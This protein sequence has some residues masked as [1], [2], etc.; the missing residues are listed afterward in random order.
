MAKTAALTILPRASRTQ[1]AFK[2]I[3]L[4]NACIR[5]NSPDE[6]LARTIDGR[7]HFVLPATKIR[8]M[9]REFV[10]QVQRTI[11]IGGTCRAQNYCSSCP[12]CWI[13]GTFGNVGDN[14][15]T[16]SFGSRLE[17][18]EAIAL[19]P[20][21]EVIERTRN[22]VE[23]VFQQTGSAGLTSMNLVPA[24]TEFYGELTI[25]GGLSDVETIVIGA[26]RGVNRVGAATTIL[27]RCSVEILAVRRGFTEIPAW[28]PQNV[29]R[30]GKVPVNNGGDAFPGL[31][32]PTYET[33]LVE[34]IKR[35]DA[36][37]VQVA[38]SEVLSISADFLKHG[39]KLLELLAAAET[40]DKSFKGANFKS[41][42]I[43][44]TST[45]K[46]EAQ[47][48]LREVVTDVLGEDK[49]KVPTVA[50]VV[51]V[52]TVLRE[53]LVDAKVTEQGA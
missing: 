8:H 27:G 20:D 15:K 40:G 5:S 47:N 37:V 48:R 52:A 33:S 3:L 1:I 43:S 31:E 23:P 14:K 32:D 24:G 35:F 44:L 2:V 25:E 7:S 51:E 11:D 13:F 39:N 29:V 50:D 49:K 30:T 22:S 26:L 21:L 4:D 38:V 28:A 17:M 10:E 19:V 18:S 12:S 42:L 9:M 45:A 6:V 53:I 36:E 46:G 41:T 34:A 16:W